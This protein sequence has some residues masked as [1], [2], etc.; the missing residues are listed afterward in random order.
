MSE[1]FHPPRVAEFYLREP[2]PLQRATLDAAADFVA[3]RTV[4]VGLFDPNCE[5]GLDRGTGTCIAVGGRYFVATAAHH[6][7]DVPEKP[8]LV[9]VTPLSASPT[10]E[11][12]RATSHGYR[13]GGKG[14]PMDVAWLEV[15][16]RTAADLGREFLSL[17]GIETGG[18]D[19]EGEPIFS[20]GFPFWMETTETAEGRAF[21]LAAQCYS[22]VLL[23]ARRI[24]AE[25][26]PDPT[27]DLFARYTAGPNDEI[28]EGRMANMPDA[29]GLSGGGFWRFNIGKPTLWTPRDVKLVG[30][31]HQYCP[32]GGW[33]RA[34][35]VHHW[36]RLVADDHPSL[37]DLIAPL[38]ERLEPRKIDPTA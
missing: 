11:I 28:H 10:R 37:R 34:T 8:Y 6:F 2:P 19:R 32:A 24:V 31:E 30:I 27:F 15:T 33:F 13:G 26:A 9:G 35:K 5:R 36:L 16:E 38:V 14:D 17:D 1:D 25:C 3:R 20:Y 29:R 23:D 12:F 7:V 21:G 22:T 4:F 18:E